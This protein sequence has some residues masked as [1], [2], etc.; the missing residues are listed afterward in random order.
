MPKTYK[1]T[2]CIIVDEETNGFRID[3]SDEGEVIIVPENY[4]ATIWT[5]SLTEAK[6]FEEEEE[7][8]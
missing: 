6:E 1:M 8:A 7:N 5:A 4:E 2:L 3:I